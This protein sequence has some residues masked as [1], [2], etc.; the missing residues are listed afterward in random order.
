MTN[1]L[2]VPLP[3]PESS[4]HLL[5]STH[6]SGRRLS[7][8]ISC[9]LSVEAVRRPDVVSFRIVRIERFESVL[10]PLLGPSSTSVRLVQLG[11]GSHCWVPKTNA[12]HPPNSMSHGCLQLHHF[13]KHSRVCVLV[14][15]FYKVMNSLVELT[16]STVTGTRCATYSNHNKKTLPTI[17]QQ[18]GKRKST[19]RAFHWLG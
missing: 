18:R 6:F 9:S 19:L 10:M 14:D 16:P 7:V 12:T 5:V 2:L 11:D 13:H 4:L 3:V 17:I 15:S 1:L 8:S